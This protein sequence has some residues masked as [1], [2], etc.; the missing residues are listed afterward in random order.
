RR[1]STETEA[2]TAGSGR[3]H[4][5]RPGPPDNLAGQQF[6]PAKISTEFPIP[7]SIDPVRPISTAWHP[8]G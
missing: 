4:I 2:G 7:G 3:L 8:G 1:W 6:S 5:G